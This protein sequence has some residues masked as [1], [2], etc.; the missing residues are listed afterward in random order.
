MEEIAPHLYIGQFSILD[1]KSHISDL[2]S[3]T[4]ESRYPVTIVNPTNFFLKG[5]M[6]L[7]GKI[8]RNSEHH[9]KM[10]NEVKGIDYTKVAGIKR[11][12]VK[13][14]TEQ[15][16]ID[17]ADEIKN[18]PYYHHLE[19]SQCKI[20]DGYAKNNGYDG[21]IFTV[22]PLY[23]NGRLR[24]VHPLS[25]PL[26]DEEFEDALAA[27]YRNVIRLAVEQN[28]DVLVIPALSAGT[29]HCPF[30]ISARVAIETSK[31]TLAQI[32]SEEVLTDIKVVLCLYDEVLYQA[33]VK[34]IND[35][36]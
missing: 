32:Y 10:L 7:D 28:I 15:E 5:G 33:Y 20:V 18:D 25:V 17:K 1:A 6:G 21:V 16:L 35:H 26:N 12:G 27:T 19:L 9:M 23:N 14:E 29:F 24:T 22:P 34:Y 11:S 31:N 4:N 36:K 30:D 8:R 13:S 2:L 3:P